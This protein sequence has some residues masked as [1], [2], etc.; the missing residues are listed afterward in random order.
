MNWTTAT[1]A[2][3]CRTTYILSLNR[4][5]SKDT[6]KTNNTKVLKKL[7]WSLSP[8]GIH[9]TYFQGKHTWNPFAKQVPSTADSIKTFV[10]LTW[11]FAEVTQHV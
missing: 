3:T 8:A 2:K 7:I 5:L 4:E 1:R 11:G 10:D 6:G 9:G